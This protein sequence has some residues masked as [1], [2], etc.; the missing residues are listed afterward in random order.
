LIICHFIS[1]LLSLNS[2]PPISLLPVLYNSCAACPTILFF[3]G[4]LFQVVCAKRVCARLLGLAVNI[5]GSPAVG[6]F[7]GGTCGQREV[8]A[9]LWFPSEEF[10]YRCSAATGWTGSVLRVRSAAVAVVVRP[11]SLSQVCCRSTVVVAGAPGGV[12]AA[13]VELLVL[14]LRG[15]DGRSGR[16]RLAQTGIAVGDSSVVAGWLSAVGGAVLRMQLRQR[17]DASESR[18]TEVDTFCAWRVCAG[19]VD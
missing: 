15:G 4:R 6:C 9:Q 11:G 19:R 14:R 13:A 8:F 17:C 10:R 1:F 12:S 16:R 3:S 2:M 18:L 5:P 7:P